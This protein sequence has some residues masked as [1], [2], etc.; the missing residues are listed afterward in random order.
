MVAQIKKIGILF[1]NSI[2]SKES[3]YWLSNN[4]F[5]SDIVINTKNVTIVM[6]FMPICLKTQVPKLPNECVWIF[7]NNFKQY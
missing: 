4:V 2:C 1:L 5:A 6:F 7:I 3:A